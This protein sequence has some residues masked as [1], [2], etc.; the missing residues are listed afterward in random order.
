VELPLDPAELV[1]LRASAAT[2]A[3]GIAALADTGA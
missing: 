1:A 3:D 2:I